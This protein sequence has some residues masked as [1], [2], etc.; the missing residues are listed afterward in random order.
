MPFAAAR[1]GFVVLALAT[2]LPTQAPATPASMAPLSPADEARTFHLPPGYRLE[3][4]ASEPMVIEPAMCT[5]D[6]DGNLFVAELRTYV[7]DIDGTDT[8]APRSRI[9]KLTDHDGDGRMDAAVTFI[10]GLVLPRVVL[11]LDDRVLVME[12]YAGILWS[13][14]DRDGDGK[15]DDREQVFDFGKSDANLEHQDSALSWGIDNWLYSAMGSR[16]LRFGA[17]GKLTGEDV[18]HQFA[19]WGLA[20]DD[21]GRAYFSSAGGERAAY[22]F[23]QPVQYGLL[24]LPEQFAPGFEEPFPLV[25]LPDVQGGTGRLKPDGT[26]NHF[27]GCCGQSIQRGS[28]LPADTYGDYFLCEPVGR[29]VRR[30]KVTVEHGKRVLRNAHPQSEFLRSTNPNFR[31]V[32]SANGPDGCLYFVDMYRG[33]IQESN[34]VK[35]DSYLRPQ[36]AKLGLDKN[37]GRGRIWR[38]V[39]AEHPPGRVP[40]LLRATDAELVAAL[41]HADGYRRDTAQKLLVLRRAVAAAPALRELVAQ[42]PS[43]LARVHALWTLDG[44]ER[45]E[46]NTLQIAAADADARVRETAVR[47]AERLLRTEAEATLPLLQQLATDPAIDVRLQVLRSLRYVDGEAGRDLVLERMAS[48]PDLELVQATGRSSLTHG[49]EA[50]EPGLASL[51]PADFVRWQHGREIYRTLCISCHGTDG[52]GVVSGELRLAPPL[53]ASRWLLQ[54]DEVPIRILLHGLSGALDGVE[55]VGN[56]M[57]PQAANSDAWI[58]DVLTY[59]RNSFGNAASPLQAAD[60]ERVRRTFAARTQVWR[61]DEL[62]ALLPVPREQM[63]KWQLTA[64][65]AADT[66]A[67]AIDA[68]T[69]TR[70][71]TGAVQQPGQWFQLDFGAP[72][73]VRELQLSARGS[74]GDYPRGYAVRS[75]TDGEHWSEP[76]STGAAEGPLLRL[77][78]A[79]PCSTRWLRIEQ[80]GKHGGLWWSIHDLQVFAQ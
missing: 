57:P 22:A 51:P 45:T 42:C 65:H 63:A 70:W 69:G 19:Q 14:R 35:P 46:L 73:A 3:L 62:E 28:A 39:H 41:A 58:A 43:P 36:V 18:P 77:V 15:A 54:S 29:L 67:R 24:D 5:W 6:A 50:L 37:V 59:A 31:P 7:Q 12:T 32:W 55:Y 76:L 33:I 60:I 1:P 64:S 34:W 2:A 16:R 38:L 23:Q 48:E 44:L 68:E 10:D 49:R 9:V 47:V 61:P 71:T 52:R 8:D 56:L 27:T 4:V 72:L 78:F 66:C 11:P 17:D 25:A 75:S 79:T 40:A 30:A 26:L 53:A 80:T 20:L 13:Y 74:D 21:L